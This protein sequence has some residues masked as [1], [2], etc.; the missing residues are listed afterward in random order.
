MKQD[1]R[2]AGERSGTERSKKAAAAEVEEEE[3]MDEIWRE[4]G[5]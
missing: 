5:Q 4:K 1:R 3:A 2:V